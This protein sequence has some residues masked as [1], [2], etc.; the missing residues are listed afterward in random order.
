MITAWAET[1]RAPSVSAEPGHTAGRA[2]RLA[3]RSGEH[4]ADAGGRA[5]AGGHPDHPDTDPGPQRVHGKHSTKA[6]RG[7]V[8]ASRV[9]LAIIC[10]I[11]VLITSN[12]AV[13]MFP[14][15]LLYH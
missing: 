12:K 8:W 15:N 4:T 11:S 10:T 13:Q 2:A 7:T 3:R 9:L 5:P 6:E 14:Y 1:T